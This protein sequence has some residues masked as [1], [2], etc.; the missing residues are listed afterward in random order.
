[1]FGERQRCLVVDD[2]L[3][4]PE[5]L[6]RFAAEHRDEFRPIDGNAYPGVCRGVPEEAGRRLG[7]YF[8]TTAR[9]HFDARRLLSMHSRLSLVTTPP[10]S[11][12]PFQW[13]CHRDGEALDARQS[14]QASVLYLFRDERLGGTSFF[15]LARPVPEIAALFADSRRMGG[16]E[17]T[18]RYGIDPGYIH[19]S[20]DY[21]KCVGSVEAR[22][23]RMIIYDGSLLHSGDIDAARALSNDPLA[24]RL[25]L[26]G[27]FTSRRNVA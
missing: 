7:E 2:A 24:G 26:N 15:E 20:N 5:S 25:T 14:I 10:E 19:R 16:R 23:N 17:F 12:R 18:Q 1:R 9:R 13:L 11:L 3:V 22:W 4:D 27:F 8:S 6:V 21:F